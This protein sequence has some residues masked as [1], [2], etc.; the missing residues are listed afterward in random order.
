METTNKE[1]QIQNT[2]QEGI[3]IREIL[4]LCI[5]KWYWFVISVVVCVGIASVSLLKTVPVFSRSATLLI[6]ETTVRRATTSD[7]ET[8]LSNGGMGVATSKLVNEIVAFKSPTLMGEVVKRLGLDVEYSTSG[9]FHDNVVYGA[10]CPVNVVFP[11]SDATPSSSFVL[12]PLPDGTVSLSQIVYYT[13]DGKVKDKNVIKGAMGDTLVTPMGR[14]I[15]KPAIASAVPFDSPVRVSKSSRKAA[16]ARFL[17]VFSATELDLKNRSDVLTLNIKDVNTER[18]ED[19]LN[20]LINVYNENWVADRNMVSLSTSGFIKERLAAL[21]S[22]LSNVD[23]EISNFKSRNLIPDV[24]AVSSMYM[25]QSAETAHALQELENQLAVSKYVG[26]TLMD[27]N[28]NRQL[29]PMATSIG[30]NAVSS[31]IN[32]YNKALLTRNNMAANSSDENPLVKDLDK[33]LDAMRNA[34]SVSMD[35]QIASLETQI[36]NLRSSELKNAQKIAANPEQAKYLLSVGR[37]QKVMESLYLYLLQKREENELSQAFAAY[38]TR[39]I[40]PPS[41]SNQPVSPQPS[42][43]LMIALLIGLAI[44]AGIIYLIDVLNTTVHTR[45][46]FEQLSVPFLGEVPLFQSTN[47]GKRRF[48]FSFRKRD[49]VPE[50]LVVVKAGKRDIINEAFRMLR[51]NLDFMIMDNK[52]KVF[53]ITSFNPGSGKTFTSANLAI[54]FAIKHNRVLVIDGDFRRTSLSLYVDLPKQGSV[55]YL[56]GF[57]DDPD[58][59]LV[60]NAMGCEGLDVLPVGKIPPN[61]S[62]LISDSKFA[63]M[64]ERYRSMYDYVFID[65]PPVD[66]VADTQIISRVADRTIFVVRSGLLD[67]SMVSEIDVMAEQRFKKL[68]LVLNG[69]DIQDPRYNY[70]AGYKYGYRYKGKYGYDYESTRG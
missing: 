43:L 59:V 9:M 67:K 7:L 34:I 20:L 39:L 25:S 61:P 58:T 65:C 35:N 45:R 48:R 31:Q 12:T 66:V 46:D 63:D 50:K 14:I 60:K 15:V 23:N 41:G 21:E 70:R 24:N 13:P 69:T 19:I 1:K 55:D 17:K 68:C 47:N 51:T 28:K 16:T 53:I 10:K 6:K 18:A 33:S 42:K 40:T 11:D 8:V 49:A 2:V 56:A 44:P 3:K 30:N 22:E 62:E 36:D 26:S 32:E 29:I 64:V 27:V 54:T 52:E 4:S 57:V 37:R 38:N 5:A